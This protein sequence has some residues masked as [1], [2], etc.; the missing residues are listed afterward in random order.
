MRILL[1]LLGLVLSAAF[2]LFMAIYL[3]EIPL[4]FVCGIGVVLMAVAFW[5]DEIRGNNNGNS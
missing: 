4:Y 1:S 2:L 5:Q 3:H